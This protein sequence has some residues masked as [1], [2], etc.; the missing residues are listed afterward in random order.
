MKENNGWSRSAGALSPVS[1]HLTGPF[2]GAAFASGA[3]VELGNLVLDEDDDDADA[4]D[5]SVGALSSVPGPEA[6]WTSE[7]TPLALVDG[8]GVFGPGMELVIIGGV[9]VFGHCLRMV[10]GGPVH[11]GGGFV[12]L[13]L[14]MAGGG[15]DF[16]MPGMAGQALTILG[17]CI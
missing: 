10:G 11:G 7:V 9:G 8:G 13:A 5:A 1:R 2:A 15:G 17:G 16:G 6:T 12:G 4:A 3:V 14:S